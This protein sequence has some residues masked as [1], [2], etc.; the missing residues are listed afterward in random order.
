MLG[1]EP[2]CSEQEKNVF[3][4][5]V[6]FYCPSEICRHD[7]NLCTVVDYKLDEFFSYMQTWSGLRNYQK[8]QPEGEVFDNFR[9]DLTQSLPESVRRNEDF[10]T[11]VFPWY[12]IACRKP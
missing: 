10:L 7:P 11:V 5:V 8:L 4:V 9:R 2:E 6:T 3:Q 12:L 1:G